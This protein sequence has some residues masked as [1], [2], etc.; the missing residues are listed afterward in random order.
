MA[1]CHDVFQT[2]LSK[3]TLSEA[4]RKDLRA[5]RNANRGRIREH[6]REVLER[7]VPLFYSQGSYMMRTGVNPLDG[8]YDIDDGIYLQGLGTD[9]SKW[10]TPETVHRWIVAATTGFTDE[11]PQDKRT[12]VRVRYAGNFHLDLP[13]YAISATGVPKIFV[14]GTTPFESDPRGFSDWFA[15]QVALLGT[16][17]RRMVRNMKGWRDYQGGGA[18]VAS[19]LALTILTANHFSGDARDDVALVRTVERMITHLEWGG[20]VTKPVRPFEDLSAR[21]TATQRSNFITKLCHLR[22]RGQDALEE[23]ERT[24]ASG[25]WNRVLGEHFPVVPEDTDKE[26]R[27][28]PQRTTRP[29]LLPTVP[30]RSA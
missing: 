9:E 1:D 24:V 11:P 22:D 23:E 10:P 7:P 12:C 6:F 21:W 26:A 16:Q 14:K 18:R 19:G 5:T 15:Q 30:A 13:I 29:A 2:Y 25:I 8:E 17:L 3:I 28:T 20:F 4:K 27:W